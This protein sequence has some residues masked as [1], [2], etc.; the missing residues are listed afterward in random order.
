MLPV[1]LKYNAFCLFCVKNMH[2]MLNLREKDVQIFF[3]ETTESM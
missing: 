2:I 3:S 1:L